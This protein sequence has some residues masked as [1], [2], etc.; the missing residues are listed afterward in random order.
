[1]NTVTKR[2]GA[3][4]FALFTAYIF[5]RYFSNGM[6][7]DIVSEFVENYGLFH[8][9]AALL[10]SW[11]IVSVLMLSGVVDKITNWVRFGSSGVK[12]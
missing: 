2:L 11:G 9:D 12:S 6:R 5:F 3:L 4:S 10:F 7:L 1:M 8:D